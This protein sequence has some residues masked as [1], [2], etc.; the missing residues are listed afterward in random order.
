MGEETTSPK[1][2]SVDFFKRSSCVTGITSE[3]WKHTRHVNDILYH[4]SLGFQS[5]NNKQKF[6]LEI[7]YNRESLFPIC[8]HQIF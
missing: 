4:K 5:E 1:K 3:D 8:T 6:E 7:N 2:D